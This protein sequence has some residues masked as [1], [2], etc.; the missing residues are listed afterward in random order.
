MRLR[1]SLLTLLVVTS[2]LLSACAAVPAPIT[3][4]LS[5]DIRTSPLARSI[6]PMLAQV[7]FLN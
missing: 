5:R 1:I 2:L 7:W 6:K 3:P 4:I